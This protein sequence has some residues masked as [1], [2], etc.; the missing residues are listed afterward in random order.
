MSEV[1]ILI[2]IV[3]IALAFFNR[4]WIRNRFF[5]RKHTNY[6]IDDQFNSD[7]REREKEIDRLLSKMGKNGIND[8]SAKDRKRLDELSKM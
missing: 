1:F 4:E 8:L 7:K 3:A 2:I 5:P 6:T